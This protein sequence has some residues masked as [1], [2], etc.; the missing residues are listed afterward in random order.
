MDGRDPKQH[1]REEKVRIG[2]LMKAKKS[3]DN[4]MPKGLRR[5]K[6]KGRKKNA[7]IALEKRNVVSIQL[8]L[9]R[10]I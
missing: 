7:G 5:G 6:G 4:E 8:Y 10:I 3:I 9:T 2:R 1:A